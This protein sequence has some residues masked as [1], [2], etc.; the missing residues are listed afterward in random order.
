M[1][2][3][4][5]TS[6]VC[7]SFSSMASAESEYL[8][9]HVTRSP[10]SAPIDL[11]SLELNRTKY[12]GALDLAKIVREMIPATLAGP[13]GPQP[14]L[15]TPCNRRRITPPDGHVSCALGKGQ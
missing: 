10:R 13:R 8:R 11:D 5:N 1:R 12:L 4:A 2:R 14:D 6:R 3:L 15:A 9:L 7:A